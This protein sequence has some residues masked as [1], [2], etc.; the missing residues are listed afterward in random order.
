MI[1]SDPADGGAPPGRGRRRGHGH[2]FTPGRGSRTGR[3][4]GR[5]PRHVT[6][7]RPGG[8]SGHPSPRRHFPWSPATPQRSLDDGKRLSQADEMS[9]FIRGLEA[10]G[11]AVARDEPPSNGYAMVRRWMPGPGPPELRTPTSRPVN[12]LAVVGTRRARMPRR[13]QPL[14]AGGTRTSLSGLI[15]CRGEVAWLVSLAT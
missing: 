1:A 11:T 5:P 13:P 12:R 7:T 9:L 15:G 3:V 6:F 4:S 8:L 14:G 10:T 2:R